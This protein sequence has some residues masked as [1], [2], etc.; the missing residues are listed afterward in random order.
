[1]LA[2]TSLM[3]TTLTA[4]ASPQPMIR[5]LPSSPWN[6][7]Y[8]NES[9]KLRRDFG[10]GA[11]QIMFELDR[12]EPGDRFNL[13]FYGA[14]LEKM[15]T[16]NKATITFG[17][18][19]KQRAYPWQFSAHL[20]PGG[21]THIAFFQMAL[22]PLPKVKAGAV[23]SSLTLGEESA[24]RSIAISANGTETH[25]FE[26]GSLAEPLA[27]MRNCMDDLLTSWGVDPKVQL[28][29]LPL[30]EGSK[31]RWITDDDFPPLAWTENRGGVVKFRLA[32]D[33]VGF[34][35]VCV[36]QEE[37]VGGKDLGAHTCKLMMQRA[38]FKP[39]LDR[40]GKPVAYFFRSF[41][42]W[43]IRQ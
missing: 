36:V 40:D 22:R 10:D 37:A 27:A 13:A 30:P 20:I 2:L 6:I 41:V 21:K 31:T 39:A 15:A 34:P 28:Q 12:S 26:T 43:V 11:N 29:R 38:R 4:A 8:K 14:P 32:V 9:C 33:A 5:H 35:T 24:V 18:L 23:L 17:D 3:M 19:P 16:A 25:I 7:Q 1:M 42:N